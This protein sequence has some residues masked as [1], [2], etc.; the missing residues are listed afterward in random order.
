MGLGLLIHALNLATSKV[1]RDSQLR[2]GPTP[3]GT[4][5]GSWSVTGTP[6]TEP[7]FPAWE[8]AP[9]VGVTGIYV[10]HPGLG[11]GRRESL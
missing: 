1:T 9:R 10:A 11:K 4:P 8:Q 5:A 7:I 3:G 6:P 2:G